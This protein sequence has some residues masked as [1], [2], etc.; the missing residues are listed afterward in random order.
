MTSVDKRL[1][2]G[3]GGAGDSSALQAGGEAFRQRGETAETS[4]S[5]LGAPATPCKIN[6]RGYSYSC[7]HR[8]FCC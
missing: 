1:C 8:R 2:V 6:D 3:F 5:E 4:K 7:S